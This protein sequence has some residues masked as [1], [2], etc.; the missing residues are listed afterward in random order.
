MPHS[1]YYDDYE[2]RINK[3]KAKAERVWGDD[4]KLHREQTS[5]VHYARAMEGSSELFRIVDDLPMTTVQRR[6]VM[7]A[8][9]KI[10]D[11]YL[12]IHRD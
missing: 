9:R 3:K 7:H 1:K 12:Q 5:V 8:L 11:S 4:F 10:N 6:D 2:D